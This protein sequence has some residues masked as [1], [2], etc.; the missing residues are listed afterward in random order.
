MPEKVPATAGTQQWNNVDPT[1]SQQWHCINYE[2]DIVSTLC[3]TTLKQRRASSLRITT[4]KA[5]SI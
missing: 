5:M 4:L 2:T 3:I 1:L